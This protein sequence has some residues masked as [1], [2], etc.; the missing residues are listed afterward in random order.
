MPVNLDADD[1]DA[2]WSKGGLGWPYGETADDLLSRLRVTRWPLYA[3]KN[4]ITEL[5]V[6]SPWWK[7]IPPEVESDLRK[8]GLLD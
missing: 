5:R 4:R 8:R 1:R 2:D 6:S 3:Q 7:S